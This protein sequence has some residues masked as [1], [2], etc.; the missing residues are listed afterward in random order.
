MKN[1]FTVLI[2]CILTVS[3]KAYP[4]FQFI[5]PQPGSLYHNPERTIV[6]RDGRPIVESSLHCKN[7]FTI[8]GSSS[9]N[10]EFETVLANDKKTIILK[11]K[12][13]FA[14]G[15][16]VTVT[17]SPGIQTTDGR[18]ADGYLFDFS[19]HPEYT[20]KQQ[21][22][23]SDARCKSMAE[24]RPCNFLS[25]DI[26]DNK[27]MPDLTILTNTNP[28]PGDVFFDNYSGIDAKTG[29]NWI[30]RSNGD[31]VF[32]KENH[33]AVND[34]NLNHNGY[35][36]MFNYYDG[37]FDVMDSSYH[38]IGT[39][40][41]ANGY[42]T[43]E[44]DFQIF[45]NGTMFLIADDYQYVDLSVYDSS[46]SSNALVKQNIVQELDLD[47]NVIFE[48]RSLDHIEVPEALHI[49][50]SSFFL[51]VDYVHAN[52]IE[53]AADGNI[54]LSCRH[55]DQVNKID[56]T[57]GQFIW[58]LGG[59][60][61]EFSF[62]NDSDQFNYQHDIRELPNGHLTLFDNGNYHIPHISYAK[63]YEL[64]TEKMEATLVWNYQHPKIDTNFVASSFM[65]SVQRLSNGNT[66]INWGGIIY[67]E[68]LPNITEVDTGKN[69]V[70]EMRFTDPYYELI[71][72]AHRYEW[73][74]CAR[75]SVKLLRTTDITSTSAKLNWSFATGAKKYTIQ[76][77]I[78]G[79]MDWQK[80]NA[81]GSLTYK[82]LKNLL[83]ATNYEWQVASVCDIG[84]NT[85]SGF[86]LLK[87]FTTSSEKDFINAH[88]A[89]GISIF[90]NPATS[91][92]YV[93]FNLTFPTSVQVRFFNI[94][95]EEKLLLKQSIESDQQLIPISIQ[96]L[97]SGIYFVE[98]IAGSEKIVQ[99]IEVQ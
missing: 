61:N 82:T 70:W 23:I 9:G 2:T 57:T 55:L 35:I 31:S 87:K 12:V 22:E 27:I 30:I 81:M 6:I 51:F 91:Q 20:A 38:R 40:H 98:C 79:K 10:H 95:G 90:P 24:E 72:R 53:K 26:P 33:S 78:A 92:L 19:I 77:R 21:K 25:A 36:T 50:L 13:S 93:R 85:K 14:F 42:Q 64:D 8:R 63:E 11:P 39:Y 16:K 99:Q 84:G 1:I 46:Y 49:N 74:P 58:R 4:Q 48:W 69:I 44:H 89:S 59:V 83:P 88:A 37:G 52:A 29:K 62:I 34:F 15:E 5:A 73:D 47:S 54:L 71:Y 97:P 45:K 76:Y 43:D 67:G 7:L 17:I 65:G 3:G 18:K 86:S 41:A 94:L 60:K 56:V 96:Q 75:P 28:A 80:T 68:N 66:F 32:E